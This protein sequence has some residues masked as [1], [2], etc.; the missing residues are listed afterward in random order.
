M[1]DGKGQSAKAVRH[2]RPVAI[3]PIAYCRL[4]I[5]LPPIADSPPPVE[6]CMNDTSP[7]PGPPTVDPSAIREIAVDVF[8]IPDHRVPLVPNI[9]IIGGRDAVLVVDTGMGPAN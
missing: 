7:N 9:G 6:T 1:R 5:A 8:V 2:S 4:P 3:L